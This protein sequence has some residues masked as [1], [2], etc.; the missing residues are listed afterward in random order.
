[1]E[2]SNIQSW[3]ELVFEHR[4]KDYGAFYLRYNYPRYLTISA[5]VVIAIFLTFMIGLH[6]SRNGKK[7]KY[8]FKKV[9]ILNYKELS[10]PPPIE[11]TSAPQKKVAVKK[12]EVEKY[13]APV[14]V[15]EEIE[16]PEEVVIVEEIQEVIT[17]VES[18]EESD[19]TESSE[20]FETDVPSEPV[21]D[22]NPRFPGGGGSFLDWLDQNLRYPVAAK[23]MGI[24][25]KVIV[26]FI[27]DENGRIS[28][29]SIYE[30]LHR[31]CDREAIRLVKIMPVWI[32]GVKNGVKIRGKH[33]L[34]I[35]FVIKR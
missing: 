25:G 3:E 34:E 22:I 16:E 17:P 15:K 19:D 28:D 11:K 26:E 20:G 5:L 31:L 32:P 30:S 4:N 1:M 23:R 7:Q 13:E 10:S 33:T 35:P 18:T 27:I 9:N 2:K 24:E 14:V 29:V 21:F 8:E 12:Q 6:N